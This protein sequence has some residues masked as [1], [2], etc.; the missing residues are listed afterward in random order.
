MDVDVQ[1]AAALIGLAVYLGMRLIDALL[2]S[3]RHFKCI[4]RW[5]A[6]DKPDQ[7]VKE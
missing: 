1:Q 3:G 2:P 5:L 6:K 7:E 4:E